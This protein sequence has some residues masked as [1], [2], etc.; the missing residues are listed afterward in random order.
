MA[1]L[2]RHLFVLLCLGF[3]AGY[4]IREQRAGNLA[5]VDEWFL[6]LMTA[7]ARANFR[8]PESTGEVVLVEFREDQ[9]SEYSAW[10]PQ[11][12]DWQL[13]LKQLQSFEPEVLVVTTPLFWGNPAPDFVPAVEQAL[14]PFPSVV[15]GV[16]CVMATEDEP[17]HP[18][19]LPDLAARIPLFQRIRGHAENPPRLSSLARVPDPAL[20]H[21][22]EMGLMT[23]QPLPGGGW[24]LPYSLADGA[25]GMLPTLLAQAAG[26][27]SQSSYTLDHRLLLGL[28]AGALLRNGVYIPLEKSGDFI[29]PA[30]ARVPT[31]NALDLM[32]NDVADIL[33]DDDRQRLKQ[34]RII[35]V[36][37]TSA[38]GSL[39]VAQAAALNEIL[40]MPQLLAMG[41]LWEW[42][43]WAAAALAAWWLATA[44]TPSRVLLA[45]AGV[46]FLA[47][48]AAYLFFQAKLVWFSPAVPGALILVGA[49]LGR[50][51]RLRKRASKSPAPSEPEKP[52]IS[53]SVP[54]SAAA[55]AEKE[56]RSDTSPTTGSAA[57]VSPK[58]ETAKELVKPAPETGKEKPACAEKAPAKPD[59]SPPPATDP[60]AAPP[61]RKKKKAE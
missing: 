33:T 7:N 16:E 40:S 41:G 39:T 34:A 30:N 9:R 48:V 49:F 28:G 24:S 5:P 55:D 18:A 25:G 35:V 27:Y 53:T 54:A 20:R 19:F 45:A 56:P 31:V 10:P 46:L 26:R 14:L 4:V 50:F 44:L 6:D 15:L 37:V 8:R 23:G 36:G 21:A 32:A 57:A 42:G 12:L 60:A 3:T 43:L 61:N 51:A 52:A 17:P 58:E 47:F 22:G 1:R 13:V 11:P 2:F 38:G 29:V 59:I